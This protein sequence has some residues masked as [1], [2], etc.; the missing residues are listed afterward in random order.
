M[1]NQKRVYEAEQQN[2]QEKKRIAELKK[3]IEMERDRE[4]LKKHA[5]EQGVIAKK[6]DKKLDWMYKKPG[7]CLN[8]EEYLLGKE[9][10]TNFEKIAQAE[11]DAS[12]NRA[13]K[14]HV[15]HGKNSYLNFSSS[16]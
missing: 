10:D 1:K 11:K 13:P 6:D 15:E 8:R 4:D 12:L 7:Q 16:K 2:I 9:I 14:N 5:M 3:E